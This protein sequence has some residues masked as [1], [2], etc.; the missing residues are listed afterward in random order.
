MTFAAPWALLGL[1]LASIPILLHLLARRE[2]P[3][4]LFP[5]TRYLAQ[6]ARL[7]QRRLQLQHLLLLLLRTL[8]IVALVFA[9]AGPSWPSTGLGAHA[10]TALVLVVDNS[11]SSGA[12]QDGVSVIEQLKGAAR[13]VLARATLEDRLWLITADGVV[14]QGT[15]EFLRNVV[16]GLEATPRR[17]ELG[18]A[19]ATGQS[20]LT[21]ADRPGET[22]I[23]TDAQRSAVAG[24]SAKGAIAVLRP[25]GSPVPNAGVGRLFVSSQPWPLDGGTA[26]VL[27]T[28]T[29]D[30]ARPVTLTLGNRPPKQLLVP[31]GGQQ[32]QR[33]GGVSP[34]WWTL[35]A[36][37]DPDELRLD[38]V[39]AVAVRVAPPARVAWRPDDRYLATAAQVLVQNG[40]LAAGSDV[41][42]GTLGSGGGGAIVLPPADP[43]QVG[44]VNR[45]LAARGA[46]WRF[47]D[48]DL[49]PVSTDSGPWL[50]RERITRRHKLEFTGGAG[51]DVLVTAGG[52]PWVVRSGRTV[53][54]GSRFDP[55][56]TSLPLAA[57]FVPFVDALVNRAARGELVHLDAS[58]G[59]PVL[60]P[61]RVTAVAGPTGPQQMEGGSAFHPVGLGVH[62]LLA[63]GDTAGAV[64][65]NP[66][67]RESD[68]TRASDA[69]LVGLWPDARVA[70]LERASEL[71]FRVGARSDLRGPLLWLA[72]ALAL[73]EAGLASLRRRS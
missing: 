42:L 16:D 33:L 31:I 40:R 22:V 48:L 71:A 23:V 5:A 59:D 53:L 35:T 32:S 2:P 56:W 49:T 14:R 57:A 28:G 25:S 47:G 67:P 44:A 9:A 15:A 30:R 55:S 26:G 36:E 52:Q 13:S 60:V 7:H 66:D 64:S 21:S 69:E 4:V 45:A 54:V 19:V 73:S 43:A 34:G 39:R 10:P 27:V 8:L 1:G 72:F 20:V 17:L 61:D 3:T 38:D 70:G 50:G 58:P 62:F 65:V 29:G 24:P 37:L 12:I 6:T 11:L 51:R 63:D 46:I 18:H 41:S 68:L